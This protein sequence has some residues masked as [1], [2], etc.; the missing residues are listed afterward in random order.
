M[1]SPSDDDPVIVYIYRFKDGRTQVRADVP[2]PELVID[3]LE[4]GLDAM[5]VGDP[6]R[7]H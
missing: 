7:T 4:T 1:T 2:D 6:V 5:D 3:M